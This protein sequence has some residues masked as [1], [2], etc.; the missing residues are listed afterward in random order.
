MT[1]IKPIGK[2]NTDFDEKFGIPRQG[3]LAA[4][5]GFITFQPEYDNPLA[6]EGIEDYDYLWII[7]GF[8]ENFDAAKH[9]R[10]RPPMLEGEYRGVFATRSSFRPNNLGLTC[11][12]NEGIEI[13]DGKVKLYISG[14]DMLNGTP[15]YD[16][17]PYIAYADAHQDARS[18]FGASFKDKKLEVIFEEKFLEI[19]PKDKLEELKSC[20]ELDVR[21]GYQRSQDKPFAF[22]FAGLDIRF[23]VKD[24]IV[25]VFDAVENVTTSVKN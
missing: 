19:F 25:R 12:K 22:K 14:V 18:G 13:T 17:K 7:W 5:K 16:I 20:L 24:G 9:M 6:F 2:L 23:T 21:A 8:S 3:A 4:S 1:N 10:V 11:V 15:V